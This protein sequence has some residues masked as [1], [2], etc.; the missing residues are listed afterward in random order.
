MLDTDKKTALV[1]AADLIDGDELVVNFDDSLA[2]A[3]TTA[4]VK[5]KSIDSDGTVTLVLSVR[6]DMEICRL[7]RPREAE[8]PFEPGAA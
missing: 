7:A 5:E 6:G 4:I 8:S 1:P 3:E 2:L